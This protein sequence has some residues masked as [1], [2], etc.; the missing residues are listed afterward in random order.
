MSY[1]MP[2][3]LMQSVGLPD[4][5]ARLLTACNAVSYLI[6]SGLAVLLVERMGRRGLMLLSTFSQFVCFLSI[7]I[8]L[9]FSASSPNG[10]KYATASIAF[11]FL[12]FG[13]FGIGMLGVP[14]LYPTEINYLPMR[15]KGA[16]VATATD[17][18]TNF[19]I[20]EITPIGIQNIGWKFWIV[21]TVSN[22]VFLPILYFFYPETANRTLEDMDAYYR[23]NPSLI[24]T[25]DPDAISQ[26]RPQK[27]IDYENEQITRIVAGKGVLS[28]SG[29][30][31]V[32][33]TADPESK[34]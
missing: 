15:T 7:T 14:W 31:Q 9:Y 19:A 6:F 24:V 5:H 22:A 3:V 13:A 29:A 28:D 2:T 21:W 1:Y 11:F 20:V 25:G 33:W 18:I 26:K 23:P 4:K 27:Y 30:E 16:A 12:Y 10:G 34:N 8:L 17:W 32:E